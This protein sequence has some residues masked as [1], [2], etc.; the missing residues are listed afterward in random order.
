M[1][2]SIF[3]YFNFVTFGRQK[4]MSAIIFWR[5]Y[6]CRVIY[7]FKCNDLNSLKNIFFSRAFCWIFK[8]RFLKWKRTNLKDPNWRNKNLGITFSSLNEAI[9]HRW[10]ICLPLMYNWRLVC[11]L[12]II[13]VMPA[14]TGYWSHVC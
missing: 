10:F 8:I 5:F 6:V 7:K 9:Q 3:N 12:G 1:Y 13:K 4:K 11:E 14:S 2:F